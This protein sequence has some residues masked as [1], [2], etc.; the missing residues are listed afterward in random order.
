MRIMALAFSRDE[1]RQPEGRAAKGAEVKKAAS[2]AY[3]TSMQLGAV[4]E[5][6]PIDYMHLNRHEA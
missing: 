1:S 3:L 6:R 4:G 5:A 2:D